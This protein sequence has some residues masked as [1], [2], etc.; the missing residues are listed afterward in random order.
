MIDGLGASESASVRAQSALSL[1]RLLLEP[2]ATPDEADGMCLLRA[3]GGFDAIAHAIPDASEITK[4]ENEVRHAERACFRQRDVGG[5]FARRCSFTLCHAL[6]HQVF[7]AL[8]TI[9]SF[10]SR[11]DLTNASFFTPHGIDILLALALE[12]GHAKRV[13]G[14][15]MSADTEAAPTVSASPSLIRKSKKRMSHHTPT[16]PELSQLLVQ[17]Q[18]R[19]HDGAIDRAKQMHLDS[20]VS[21]EDKR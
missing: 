20:L 11:T 18:K 7:A 4:T 14:D 12:P 16:A 13:D 1:A 6:C 5:P 9:I 2:P 17:H 8:F 21:H 15:G 19:E 10:V 3:G